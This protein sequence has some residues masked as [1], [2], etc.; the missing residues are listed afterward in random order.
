MRRLPDRLAAAFKVVGR[1]RT[2]VILNAIW[3]RSPLLSIG[4]EKDVSAATWGSPP[5]CGWASV[6]HLNFASVAIRDVTTTFL[7]VCCVR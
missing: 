2:A 6:R 3:A 4:S 5:R 7:F 1:R